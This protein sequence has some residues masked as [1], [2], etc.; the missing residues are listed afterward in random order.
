MA[1]SLI[2]W[3]EGVNDAAGAFL[4]A[5]GSNFGSVCERSI[6]E[7]SIYER[8]IYESIYERGAYT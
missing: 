8:T 1:P 2:Y 7:R 5:A 6:Y 3:Y 4:F